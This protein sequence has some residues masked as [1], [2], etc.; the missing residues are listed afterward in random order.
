MKEKKLAVLAKYGVSLPQ[1]RVMDS[2]YTG[3][4][5]TYE[6]EHLA[7][8]TERLLEGSNLQYR[9]QDYL[10]AIAECVEKGWLRTLSMPLPE[11]I[12][13]R[14][15]PH[16]PVVRVEAG[17]ARAIG[18]TPEG[19]LLHRQIRTENF[20]KEYVQYSDSGWV[21]D[22]QARQVEIFAEKKVHCE[23]RL[24]EFLSDVAGHLG[25][26]AEIE[27]TEGPAA[28]GAWRP[29]PFLTIPNGFKAVIKFKAAP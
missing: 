15:E 19:Y 26:Q 20:G 7:Y 6:P 25:R 22:D 18:F 28:T 1:Y 16:I 12:L 9:A 13:K 4:F 2:V 17:P 5:G 23:L 24:N 11:S 3:A 21:I 27:L 14:T 10:Q 8:Y 29:E